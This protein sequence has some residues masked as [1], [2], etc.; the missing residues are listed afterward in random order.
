MNH[1][2]NIFDMLGSL[3]PG[4]MGYAEKEGRRNCD[5]LL[6]E[7]IS[8]DLLEF[9]KLLYQ[10]MNKAMKMKDKSKMNEIEDVRKR[11]NTFSSK[12]KYSAYGA[13]SFFADDK[14]SEGELDH[15]YQL[16]IGLSKGIAHLVSISIDQISD[17][18]KELDKCKEILNL[19]TNYINE[20]K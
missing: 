14:I 18:I 20:F 12:I 10:D 1:K 3:I 16:D 4:Y 2:K 15:I 19:R 13:S 7:S 11:I 6:R 8:S 17:I 5:K 9:E